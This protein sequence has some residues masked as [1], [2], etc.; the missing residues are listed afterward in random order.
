MSSV[1]SSGVAELH[2]ITG[3]SVPARTRL[4]WL[5]N[6]RSGKP[7]QELGDAVNVVED[8]LGSPEDIA[9]LDF[10]MC[11]MSGDVEFSDINQPNRTSPEH[12]YTTDLC[13]DLVM[14]SWSRKP[15]HVRWASGTEREIYNQSMR[16]SKKYTESP[17]LIQGANVREKIA[18]MAVA[19]AAR[20]FSTDDG[21]S[22]IVDKS[23]VR[24]IVRFIDHLYG[25]EAFG[26]RDRSQQSNERRDRAESMSLETYNDIVSDPDLERFLRD[27]TNVS[28]QP[29][30][31]EREMNLKR[32]EVNAKISKYRRWG[33]MMPDR[34]VSGRIKYSLAPELIKLLR[35]LRKERS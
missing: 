17:P 10:A 32:E 2:K 25:N 29:E 9:R 1:R 3:D 14:W 13:H 11:A 34:D 30:Q 22:L 6:P 8:L 5:G 28:F 7:M 33:M 4:V 23:H 31:M 21:E 16:M 19:L 12:I 18:R 35:G 20:T 27:L 15:H 26:Y 24:D